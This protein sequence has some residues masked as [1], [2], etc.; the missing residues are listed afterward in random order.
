MDAILAHRWI[1]PFVQLLR[2]G[3]SPEKLSLTIALGAILGVIPV[4][5][6][7]IL[8][9]TLAAVLLR[10]NLPAIQLV[11][12]LVYPLQ[13]ILLIPFYKMGAWL[14]G[15][16][17]GSISVH[18]VTSLIRSGV[19]NA[20]RTLW[21]ITLH[22]LVAWMAFGAVVCVVVYLALVVLMRTLWLRVRQ[23]RLSQQ[24]PQNASPDI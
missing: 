17:A 5:G 4:L 19:V 11:N 9:C 2:Q 8:L 15:A 13:L 18:G 12:G 20:V 1:Q 14:F 3:V 6:S 21:V 22:A 23:S 16:D 10:L 7:T 24:A